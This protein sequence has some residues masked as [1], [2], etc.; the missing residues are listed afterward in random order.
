MVD[1]FDVFPED[2]IF[3]PGSGEIDDNQR[4]DS[5]NVG[6]G[7][8]GGAPAPTPTPVP[9]PRPLI[10]VSCCVDDGTGRCAGPCQDY[11]TPDG[12]C[13]STL[14]EDDFS[15]NELAFTLIPCA[16]AP[17]PQP[18]PTPTPRPT[19]EPTPTPV[20]E[21]Q[22]VFCGPTSGPEQ[23]TEYQ[24][25]VTAG[26]DLSPDRLCGLVSL[27][28]LR[29]LVPCDPTPI[30]TPTP[31]PTPQPGPEPTPTPT[32]TRTPTPT[33]TRTP[34]PTPTR[35]TVEDTPTPTPTPRAATPTPTPTRTPTPTP[36]PQPLIATATPTPTP[37][38]LI[39]TAT[40]TPTPTR[41][42][43]PTPTR[44][45]TP[46][47]TPTPVPTW[48]SCIDGKLKNGFPPDDYVLRQFLGP[49][50]GVCYE[51]STFIGFNPSL[52]NIRY[53]YQ[54]GSS[55]F[56]RSFEFE[57]TNPSAAISY[58][59]NFEVDTKLFEVVPR[60]LTVGPRETSQKINISVRRDNINEFGD[61]ITNF[62]LKVN[63]EEI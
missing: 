23:C 17:P 30:A 58:L 55:Q 4:I 20:S 37:L 28:T 42:P 39:A 10:L 41:T 61:G 8:G 29:T 14:A 56:P 9:T 49:I 38:P 3:G 24:V 12:L 46:T 43:T 47:P 54:R 36:T 6:G 60:R 16:F 44:T 2:S 53:I 63:V 25:S 52:D 57:I 19:P 40:P 59:I 27:N 51:P 31:T 26:S 50:G 32:P 11:S 22:S 35:T 7:G 15:S 1:G 21:I 5:P 48:R 62:D 13:P 34:T 33:P 18:T 45:P